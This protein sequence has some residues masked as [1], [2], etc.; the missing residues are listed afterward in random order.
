MGILNDDEKSAPLAMDG[1]SRIQKLLSV[2]VR[3]TLDE[4]RY[5]AGMDTVDEVIKILHRE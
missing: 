5:A 2:S 4:I 3:L 1:N